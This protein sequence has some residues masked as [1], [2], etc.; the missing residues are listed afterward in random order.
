MNRIPLSD[1]ELEGEEYNSS[2]SADSYEE[3]DFNE[4]PDYDRWY[5]DPSEE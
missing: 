3:L 2:L 1:E 5:I 4:K